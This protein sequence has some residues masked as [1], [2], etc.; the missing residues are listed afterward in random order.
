[1][2]QP[3]PPPGTFVRMPPGE[4]GGTAKAAGIL[5]LVYGAWFLTGVASTIIWLFTPGP[6][7]APAELAANLVMSILGI[8]AGS[9]LLARK[10]TGQVLA[11]VSSALGV[12]T[13]VADFLLGMNIGSFPRFYLTMFGPLF[14]IAILVL[15]LLRPTWRWLDRRTPLPPAGYG[16]PQQH[17]IGYPQQQ[18]QRYPQAPGYPLHHQGY[19]PPQQGVPPRTQRPPGF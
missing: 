14:P 11:I 16:Y 17:G 2:G 8:L 1:M 12:L 15:A 10:R 6:S 3:Y 13:L 9:L 19:P 18:Q 7:K 4:Q 5:A